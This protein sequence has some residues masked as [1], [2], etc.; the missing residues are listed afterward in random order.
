MYIFVCVCVCNFED[1]PRSIDK[2]SG[3]ILVL[4]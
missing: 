1:L 3:T 4:G 2:V